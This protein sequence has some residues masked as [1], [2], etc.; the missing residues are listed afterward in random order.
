MSFTDDWLG[1]GLPVFSGGKNRAVARAAINRL[2]GPGGFKTTRVTNPD[3]SVTTVQ[4]KGDMPPQI[5]TVYPPKKQRSFD[6]TERDYEAR[7]YVS[8]ELNLSHDGNYGYYIF[9]YVK[10]IQLFDANGNEHT[11]TFPDPYGANSYADVLI[12][13]PNK[14]ARIPVSPPKTAQLTGVTTATISFAKPP[15][16]IDFFEAVTSAGAYGLTFRKSAATNKLLGM[17]EG[18]ISNFKS[19]DYSFHL[20]TPE[21]SL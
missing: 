9:D 17:V 12:I 7:T 16:E 1:K 20:L 19:G 8:V 15:A 2:G 13:P 18:G 5:T 10:T 14:I 6:F 4:L 11:L 3:G 21:N